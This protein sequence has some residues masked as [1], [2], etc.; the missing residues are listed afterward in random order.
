MGATGYVLT[1]PDEVL[2]KLEL[3]DTKI[4]AIAESSEKTANRFNQAFSS[5]PLSVHPLI[6]RLDALKNIGKLHLGSVLKKYTS[7]S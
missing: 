7:D 3:A 6:K 5:M 2:K 4:N 1:I